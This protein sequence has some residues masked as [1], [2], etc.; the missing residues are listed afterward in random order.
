[1]DRATAGAW[2]RRAGSDL[3]HHRGSIYV[4]FIARAW[5]SGYQSDV[6]PVRARAPQYQTD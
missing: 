2:A 1:M 5:A 6:L 3:N 4:S